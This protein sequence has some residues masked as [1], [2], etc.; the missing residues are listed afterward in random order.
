MIN[1]P[2]F[3]ANLLASFSAA[4]G[5]TISGGLAS[6][7]DIRP[8]QM[9]NNVS[10]SAAITTF[11]SIQTT[12]TPS[13]FFLQTSS[14]IVAH[15]PIPA[16]GSDVFG[17]RWKEREVI[18]L[19]ASIFFIIMCCVACFILTRCAPQCLRR[20][21]PRSFYCQ[22]SYSTSQRSQLQ[23]EEVA[24][25]AEAG[26]ENEHATERALFEEAVKQSLAT[27]APPILIGEVELGDRE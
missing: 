12:P 17:T 8:S 10:T 4:V 6:Q 23:P 25:G 14:Q 7:G 18:V 20:M 21:L 3:L 1:S 13:S 27:A 2:S 15:T 26:G 9:T 22:D 24:G 19:S 16:S 5:N 11:A